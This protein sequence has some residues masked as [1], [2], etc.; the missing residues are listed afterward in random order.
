MCIAAGHMDA[1][2]TDALSTY[3]PYSL[4]GLGD[5]SR[6]G[7]AYNKGMGGIGIGVKD[8]RFLNYLN[9]AAIVERD[10]LSFM[11]DFGLEQKNIYP[12]TQDILSAYNSFNVYNLILSFPL[13]RRSAIY[14]GVSPFSDV[15]YKIQ[16][17]ETDPQIINEMGDV[18]Y[19]KYG[20]GG[21]SKLFAGVS[22]VLF[23]NMTLGVEG[24]YYFGTIDRFSNILFT[25]NSEYRQINTGVDYVLSSFS[26]KAGLM[27]S[28]NFSKDLNAT[29]GATYA[30]KS[31]LSGDYTRYATAVNATGTLDTAF[32]AVRNA[33]IDIPAE[34]GAGIS[35][36]K[37]DKWMIGADYVRQDWSATNFSPTPGIDFSPATS[38]VFK[39]GFEYIPNR[40]DVRYYMKRVTYRGGAYYEKSYMSMDGKQVDNVG[41]TLGVNLP[42]YMGYNFLGVAVNVG[43]RGSLDRG[44]LR[45]RYVM[46]VLNL[47]LNDKTWFRK[48]RYD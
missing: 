31:N 6:Q 9:P 48:V 32:F 25:T 2:V 22:V 23:K 35:L 26:G 12:Q 43:Q 30:F 44:Q 8:P 4:F 15:G 17:T 28:V 3:N 19:Q 37:T 18:K 41:L 27:Y 10:S 34:I 33:S 14:A 13:Y 5:I 36:R 29:I 7:T 16:K 1:Q 42:I 47:S 40:F 39:A 38:H 46:F 45:E 21:I 20:T 24:N 11:L